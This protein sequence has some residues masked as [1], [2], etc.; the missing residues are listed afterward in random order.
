MGGV[1]EKVREQAK[2]QFGL[3]TREQALECGLDRHAIDWRLR[4]GDWVR[5]H[6]G[7]YRLGGTPVTWYQRARA[8][9]MLGGTSS[10]LSHR[11]AGF[12]F[13]LDGLT[14]SPPATLDLCVPRTR[15]LGKSP[16]RVHRTRTR[17]RLIWLRRLPVIS[18]AETLCDLAGLLTPLQL[19]FALD[20][21]HRLYPASITWLGKHIDANAKR[22][23]KGLA[24]LREFLALRL[25]GA[26]DSRL[27]ADVRRHLRAA[28]LPPWRR[29]LE[30]HHHDERVM[31]VDF[32][33]P[34]HRVAL[35]VDGY[36]WH[37]QRE[38][39]ERDAR[40]R[41]RLA[42]LGW[43]SLVITRRGLDDAA[44][45]A[46]LRLTL[47]ARAPQLRLPLGPTFPAAQPAQLG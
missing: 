9:T 37:H 41:S 43:Q 42:A 33:W 13:R 20:A 39:F 6:Q 34:A 1:D 26:T 18:I 30:V 28:D 19:E 35:H 5:V 24:T 32:A 29:Q 23:L 38:R 25:D 14:D 44:W 47:A 40:Q 21:A 16:F 22:G 31:R 8:A 36:R 46:D 2:R 45:L 4:C 12:L 3:V 10:A 27:E 11:T 15:C 7:V 17:P